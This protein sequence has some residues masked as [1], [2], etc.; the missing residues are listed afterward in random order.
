MIVTPQEMSADLARSGVRVR[1]VWDLVN[2]SDKYPAA[3]P[4]LIRWLDRITDL[5]QTVEREK[6]REGIIRSLSVSYARPAAAQA[7]INQFRVMPDPK[8]LGAG[9]V[10]GN[11]LGVVADHT[12]ADEVIEILLD[13]SLGRAR[14]MI[15]E[16]IPRIA[17]RRP[18][19]V[20]SVRSL[21][22]DEAVRPFVIATLGR[23]GD[24]ESREQIAAYVTSD[25]LLT[26]RNAAVALKRID[27]ARTQRDPS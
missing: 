10:A 2:T 24:V 6:L 22:D 8:G 13:R 15:F 25:H 23:L 3:V 14:E 12:V 4:V 11:A 26:S 19:V 1:D 17:K 5:P 16:A 9:W 20:L 7:I 21:L 18:E 27:A